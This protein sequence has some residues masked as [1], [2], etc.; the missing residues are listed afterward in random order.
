MGNNQR[1]ELGG[2][3][4]RFT[5]PTNADYATE[6]RLVEDPATLTHSMKKQDECSD[7]FTF[8]DPKQTADGSYW[9]V[10]WSTDDTGDHAAIFHSASLSSQLG[11]RGTHTKKAEPLIT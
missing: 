1:D 6:T 9:V 5:S 4:W 7:C 8:G 3:R 11:I 2:L 10:G